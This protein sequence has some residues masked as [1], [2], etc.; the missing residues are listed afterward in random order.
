MKWFM[1]LIAPAVTAI[2]FAEASPKDKLPTMNLMLTILAVCFYGLLSGP[3]HCAQ[4]RLSPGNSMDAVLV[5]LVGEIEPGDGP[6]LKRLIAPYISGTNRLRIISLN[7]DGGDVTTA[8]QIGRVLR[9]LEFDTIVS[10]RSR[11]LSSC[12]FLLAAGL[13]KTVPGNNLVGIHRPF[14]TATGS[15]SR[16]EASKRYREWMTQIN[17]YFDEMNVPRRLTE[18][19]LS[20]PPEQIRMLSFDEAKQFGLAGKDPVAQEKDDAANAK[21]FGLSRKEYLVRRSRALEACNAPPPTYFDTNCY[22]AILAGQR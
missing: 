15:M 7:S 16:E 17:S 3:A 12:V 10:D 19:M 6:A 1:G 13:D 5:E 22:N 14:G 21:R 2:A 9:E 4:L 20:V 11:C 18:A 8:L